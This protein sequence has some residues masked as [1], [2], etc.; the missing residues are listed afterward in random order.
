MVWRETPLESVVGVADA[1]SLLAGERI[2]DPL[3]LAQLRAADFVWLAK[4]DLLAPGQA[5]AAEGALR[6][7]GVHGRVLGGDEFGLLFGAG[8][9]AAGSAPRRTGPV[10]ERFESFAWTG[11]ALSLGRFQAAMQAL[12]PRLVR[13]KGVLALDDRAQPLLFQMVGR[14]ATVAP[15]PEEARRGRGWC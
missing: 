8:L 12:S 7:L 15:A 9:H 3:L 11:G 10:A 1:A 2:D 6:T 5:A 13:A 14:R 4:L